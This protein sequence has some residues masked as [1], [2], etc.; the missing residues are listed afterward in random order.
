VVVMVLVVLVVL[1]VL[2]LLLLLLLL[3]LQLQLLRRAPLRRIAPQQAALGALFCFRWV[4]RRGDFAG[5]AGR[6]GIQQVNMTL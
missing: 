4:L 3:T 6:R 1:V 5:G 2:L